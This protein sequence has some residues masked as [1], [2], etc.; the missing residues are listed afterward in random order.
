MEQLNAKTGWQNTYNMLA[1]VVSLISFIEATAKI[2]RATG[3]YESTVCCPA[4]CFAFSASQSNCSIKLPILTIDRSTAVHIPGIP[5]AEKLHRSWMP[6]RS[7]RRAAL[8]L[9]VGHSLRSDF[10]AINYAFKDSLRYRAC[11]VTKEIE[12]LLAHMLASCNRSTWSFSL[13]AGSG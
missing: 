13:A 12:T 5:G 3:D 4:I 6:D 9:L 2:M 8:F 10:W 7:G 11:T 1:A